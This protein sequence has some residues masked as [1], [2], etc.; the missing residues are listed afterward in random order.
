[1]KIILTLSFLAI[2]FLAISQTTLPDNFQIGNYVEVFHTD[3][4]K[5]YFNCTGTV[6]DKKCAYCYRVGKMDPAKINVTG[7]FTDYYVNGKV[8]LNATMLNNRLEGPAHYYYEDGRIKEEGNY[9]NNTRQGKWTFYYPNGNVQKIYEYSDSE[10]LVLEAYKYNGKA[11]VLNKSGNFNTE[12]SVDKQCDK[13]MASGQIKNGKKEGERKFF[14][15]PTAPIPISF[16]TYSEGNF[17]KGVQKNDVYTDKPRIGLT[18]FYANENLNL[19]GNLLGCPGN[20]IMSWRYN[21][22]DVNE[23]FYPE[24]QDEL[25]K[26]GKPIQNQWLVVG[27]KVSKKNEIEEINIASSINDRSIESHIYGLLS[28]MTQWETASINS[29]KIESNIF[30]TILIVSSQI[31]IP[32]DYV[33]RNRGN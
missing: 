3:S 5:I 24:L 10:P 25:S 32:T 23:S 20:S 11:T 7:D 33:F 6:A 4:I 9:Q 31:I 12:F 27:I 28:K 26:Y 13:Y 29:G 8:F 21:N 15:S 22:Q 17:I 19:F 18:N 2:H 14:A 16:E 30:F 1:M